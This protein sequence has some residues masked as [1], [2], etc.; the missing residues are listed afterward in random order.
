MKKSNSLLRDNLNNKNINVKNVKNKKFNSYSYYQVIN[1][2][3]ELFIDNIEKIEDIEDNINKGLK[4]EYY[5]KLFNVKYGSDFFLNIC[6][7]ICI[8]YNIDTNGFQN[9]AS[10]KLKIKEKDYVHHCYPVGTEY[11]EFIRIYKFEHELRILML[12]YTLIIEENIKS[13]FISTLNDFPNVDSNFLNDINNYDTSINN[14][15]SIDTIKKIYDKQKNI[16]SKPIA[17]KREQNSVIPYWIIINELTMN[18]TYRL[19]KNLKFEYQDKII[20][21]LLLHFS[22][23]EKNSSN[24]KKQYRKGIFNIIKNI[25]LF[26]NMLAHNQPLYP[27][28][29]AACKVESLKTM[30]FNYPFVIEKNAEPKDYNKILNSQRRFNSSSFYDF[31]VLFGKDKFNLNNSGRDYNLSVIIYIIYKII[32]NIDKNNIMKKELEN[33]FNKYNLY[34]NNSVINVKDMEVIYKLI[35]I[36]SEVNEYVKYEDLIEIIENDKPYKAILK[37]S[38][39]IR[40][41]RIKLLE[42]TIRS[43]SLTK[44]NIKYQPFSASIRYSEFTGIDNLF[45]TEIN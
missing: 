17:R 39:K 15:D 20:E 29:H 16:H 3:K 28:N 27:Y 36:A 38:L 11:S 37:S 31:Q 26:R 9:I 25:G 8:K 24:N 33:L 35:S 42:K 41:E 30:K 1:A 18:E 4:L 43:I 6:K 21:N 13:I 12:K 19:I 2:Y 22:L 14:S 5:E 7:K 44:E 23:V 45:F 34:I 32:C 10:Y 40:E